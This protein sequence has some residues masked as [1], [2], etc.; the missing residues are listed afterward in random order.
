[1][2]DERAGTSPRLVLA[3]L[4][5]SI[6]LHAAALS[7]L[8]HFRRPAFKPATRVEVEL[9]TPP[10]PAPEESV[11]MAP[12]PARES[13][14]PPPEKAPAHARNALSAKPVKKTRPSNEVALPV[15]AAKEPAEEKDSHVVLEVPAARSPEELPLGTR[16]GTEP[17]STPPAASPDG[18]STAGTG[19]GTGDD[20]SR[21]QGYL[22]RLHERASQHRNY[23]LV[24]LRRGWQGRARVA[25]SFAA[26]GA[27]VS[28]SLDRSSGHDV[29]DEQAVEM[30]RKAVSE[31]PI[32]ARLA[33]RPITVV[34][35]VEFK[36][37]SS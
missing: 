23:P 37:A 24:A 26:G 3:A 31:L 8:P 28:V 27:V 6:G 7:F 12:T 35:P 36:L 33:R 5:I 22:R 30:V 34:V 17:F 21:L 9:A 32:E 10:P 14:P 1:M 29:L 19:D 4:A 25:V 11:E 18:R 13:P 2:S 15:L 20:E 16:P